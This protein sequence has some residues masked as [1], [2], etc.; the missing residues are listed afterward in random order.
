MIP[1]IERWCFPP[2]SRPLMDK[3]FFIALGSSF[4]HWKACVKALF[5]YVIPFLSGL[6]FSTYFLLPVGS[7]SSRKVLKIILKEQ[8][9]AMIFN[10]AMIKVSEKR[11]WRKSISVLFIC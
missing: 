11:L 2:M 6:V 8:D 1:S 7:S 5:G 10:D 9:R 4:S 3:L